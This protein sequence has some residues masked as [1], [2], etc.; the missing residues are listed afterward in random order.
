MLLGF[1]HWE[2]IPDEIYFS[3]D[4]QLAGRVKVITGYTIVLDSRI[5][6]ESHA[7][8][9]PPLRSEGGCPRG[10]RLPTHVINK[11]DIYSDTLKNSRLLF[12][13]IW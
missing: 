4:N 9:P 5:R 12:I 10:L 1:V 8:H 11:L 6:V 7:F 13:S 3:S 2:V